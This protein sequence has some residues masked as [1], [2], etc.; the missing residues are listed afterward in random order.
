MDSGK[1]TD[2][3]YELEV[4]V[5]KKMRK[6]YFK[7]LIQFSIL[8]LAGIFVFLFFLFLFIDTGSPRLLIYVIAFPIGSYFILRYIVIYIKMIKNLDDDFK[9]TQEKYNI[10]DS[11]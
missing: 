6:K 4:I 11:K 8:L 9:K 10:F 5:F 2:L 3:D 7:T 1:G